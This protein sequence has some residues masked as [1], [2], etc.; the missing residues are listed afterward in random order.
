MLALGHLHPAVHPPLARDCTARCLTGSA[1]QRGD[2]S[3][4]EDHLVAKIRALTLRLGF[5]TCK[6]G[7]VKRAF[8]DDS[9]RQRW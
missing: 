2:Q 6:M 4:A 9:G 7:L 3:A 5:P 1:C 8:L